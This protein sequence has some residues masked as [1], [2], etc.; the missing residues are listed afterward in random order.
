M[1][2]LRRAA[3]AAAFSIDLHVQA[4]ASAP[5]APLPTETVSLS[6]FIVSTTGDEGYRAANTLAGTRMNSDLFLTPAAISVMTR[7]FIED[8]GASKTEDFLRYAT[9]RE[10]E[11]GSEANN[12]WYDAPVKIRGFAGATV[13]R[14][15]FPWALSSD[16]FNI[17]RIDLN[18]GPNAVLYGV[19]SPGGVLNT[20]SKMAPLNGRKKSATLTFGSWNRKRSEIDLAMPLM[21]DRLAM[22][23]NTVLEDRDGWR[24]FEFFRQK[25]LAA[26]G[27]YAPFRNTVL[28]VGYERV[29]R[30]QVIPTGTPDDLGGTRWLAAG[31]PLAGNPLPGSNPAPTLLRARTAE[32]V[33]Y[34]P[35]LRAQPFRL[36]TVGADMRPDLAGNQAPGHWDTLP[37]SATLTQ[38]NVDDPFLG[39][40]LPLNASLAGPGATTHNHYTVYSAFVEQTYVTGSTSGRLGLFAKSGMIEFR[41]LQI[42]AMTPESSA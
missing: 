42:W 22:R 36:S 19:G 40:I 6:P 16:T 15:Y 7:E 34:A 37:G 1:K 31:A 5:V 4:Q 2:I 17:E 30:E 39:S 38:G 24:D 3:L 14:D 18:R 12:Q 9:I 28:R 10:I 23:V 20:S 25:G 33:F 13:T 26:A 41:D 11:V 21:P 8:I 29:F 32:Q 27:T 35:Q